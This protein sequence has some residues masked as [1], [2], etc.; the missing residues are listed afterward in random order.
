MFLWLDLSMI[1]EICDIADK[2]YETKISKSIC[3]VT[4]LRQALVSVSA[5]TFRKA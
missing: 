3:D 5:F 2:S 4:C 1:L